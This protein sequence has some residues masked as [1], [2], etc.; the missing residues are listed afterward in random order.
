[1]AIHGDYGWKRLPIFSSS[2]AAKE[3]VKMIKWQISPSLTHFLLFPAEFCHCSGHYY[4]QMCAFILAN[5][6][7]VSLSVKMRLPDHLFFNSHDRVVFFFKKKGI[8]FSIYCL[9][10]LAEILRSFMV[11]IPPATLCHCLYCTQSYNSA[12]MATAGFILGC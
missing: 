6:Y 4:W 11:M 1:M 8:F 3:A 12:F 7:K 9:L 5:T 2:A 10:F